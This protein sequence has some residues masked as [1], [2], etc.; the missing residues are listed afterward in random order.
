MHFRVS[1]LSIYVSIS[2][3]VD[4]TNCYTGIPSLR[5]ML[6]HLIHTHIHTS[7]PSSLS[8]LPSPT[9]GSMLVACE[10]AYPYFQVDLDSATDKAVARC[11]YDL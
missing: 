11:G 9:L 7:F 2:T 3:D 8:L 6:L 10:P 4:Q 1:R 5:L